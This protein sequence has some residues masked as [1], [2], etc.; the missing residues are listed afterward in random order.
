[1][2]GSILNDSSIR[3]C[4]DPGSTFDGQGIKLSCGC[5]CAFI[6]DAETKPVDR[7][8]PRMIAP[9]T[10]QLCIIVLVLPRGNPLLIRFNSDTNPRIVGVAYK[11]EFLHGP[12][13]TPRAE[14]FA[15]QHPRGLG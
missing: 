9:R 2:S 15:A 3:S 12:K 1:M 14:K 4:P 6:D 11:T 7:S 13:W 5:A 8:I 10:Q